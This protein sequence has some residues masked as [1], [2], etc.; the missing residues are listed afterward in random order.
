MNWNHD[1]VAHVLQPGFDMMKRDFV[2]PMI[3]L[4]MAH[5]LM[6]H[7]QGILSQED[8]RAILESCQ[9]MLSHN[10]EDEQYPGDVED[11]FFLIERR[12]GDKIGHEVTGNMHMAMSR[13]DLDTAMYRWVLRAEVLEVGALLI[14]LREVLLSKASCYLRTVMPAHTHN[15]QAQPTTLGHY[16]AGV[17]ASFSRDHFRIMPLF[18]RINKSTLGACALAT[19]G[20]EIDRFYTASLLGYDGLVENSYEAICATDYMA[21]TVGV[22]GSVLTTLSRLVADLL[23]WATNEFNVV[24]LSDGFVQGSSIM[25]QK[26]NPVGLEHLRAQIGRTLGRLGT[27]YTQVKGVPFG[28]VNDVGDDIQ[29]LLRQVLKET[30]D[31][32]QL[33]TSVFAEMKVNEDVLLERAK[34]GFSTITELADTLARGGASFRKAH[35]VASEVVRLLTTTKRTLSELKL[36]ELDQVCLAKLGSVSG[37]T[38]QEF[39]DVLDPEHFVKVRKVIGGPSPDVLSEYL[40]RSKELLKGQDEEITALQ[41]R[42]QKTDSRLDTHVHTFVSKGGS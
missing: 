37:F 30:R 28:D 39:H 35:G 33:S 3:R 2:I 21:E 42:L 25:P 8:A 19:T 1:Y 15:Q 29:P 34:N 32:L 5:V 36:D 16:F 13:N 23:L 38:E 17:E 24:L 11:L 26:R 27:F 4:S 14:K 12:I 22:V 20:F 9:E 40:G 31:I 10:W 6:L 41:Q 7:K 18:T